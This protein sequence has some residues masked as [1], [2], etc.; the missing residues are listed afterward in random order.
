MCQFAFTYVLDAQTNKHTC[1]HEHNTLINSQL[2]LLHVFFCSC[3]VLD[4]ETNKH[5]CRHEHNTLIDSQLMCASR[6]FLQLL[7]NQET[8]TLQL[9]Q[10][11]AEAVALCR[12]G[13]RAESAAQAVQ[14]CCQRVNIRTGLYACFFRRTRTDNSPARS[15]VGCHREIARRT[16]C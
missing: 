8:R 15:S 1:R 14:V 12:E 16:T 4:A 5:T 11:Q 13:R 3:H 10:L 6:V 7:H 9:Q 2:T